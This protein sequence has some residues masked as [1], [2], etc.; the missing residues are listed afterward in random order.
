MVDTAK[1]N[2]DVAGTSRRSRHPSAPWLGLRSVCLLSFLR[3]LLDWLPHGLMPGGK[4]CST[5]P[6]RLGR[7]TCVQ[8]CFPSGER[9]F[10]YSCETMWT[11][12]GK[13]SGRATVREEDAERKAFNTSRGGRQ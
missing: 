5:R 3:S 6:T 10:E 12:V 4:C 2:T 1:G 9:R 8:A 13:L 7:P 11:L